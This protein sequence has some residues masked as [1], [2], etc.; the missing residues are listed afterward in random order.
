M[1]LDISLV[2]FRMYHGDRLVAGMNPGLG[3]SDARFLPSCD[4]VAVP[5]VEA[6]HKGGLVAFGPIGRMEDV[7]FREVLLTAEGRATIREAEAQAE[8]DAR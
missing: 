5:C 4:R 8:A 3:R 2:L 1:I 7:E 6:L